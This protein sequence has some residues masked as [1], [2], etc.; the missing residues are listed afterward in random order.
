MKYCQE[1]SVLQFYCD[2][3]EAEYE[4][5]DELSAEEYQQDEQEAR[6]NTQVETKNN[7]RL[8]ASQGSSHFADLTYN[9]YKQRNPSAPLPNFENVK[10]SGTNRD[11][12]NEKTTNAN[13]DSEL[14][15]LSNYR[16]ANAYIENNEQGATR[17]LNDNNLKLSR[18]QNHIQYDIGIN[19]RAMLPLNTNEEG[20][21]LFEHN[22]DQ[23]SI[24]KLDKS[25]YTRESADRNEQSQCSKQLYNNIP[26]FRDFSDYIK[27]D[28][29]HL[30][31]NRDRR[32][33]QENDDKET[34]ESTL[35]PEENKES[36]T[37][38]ED[39]E[40]AIKR[41]VKKL[42][43]QELE[44][45]FNTLSEDKRALLKKIIETDYEKDNE[46]INKREITKKAGT[47]EENNYIENGQ[48]DSS[49]IQGGCSNID[50]NTEPSISHETTDNNK[51]NMNLTETGEVLSNK[52]NDGSDKPESTG[53]LG[54]KNENIK[55]TKSGSNLDS[56]KLDNEANVEPDT[57][58]MSKTENKRETNINENIKMEK[59]SDSLITD[60]DN[61]KNNQERFSPAD[62]S[63]LINEETELDN[64]YK[65]NIKR[66]TSLDDLSDR[67]AFIKS[68]EES[69]P[70]SN[71]YD[72]TNVFSGSNMAP[73]I[74]VKRKNAESAMTKRS[75]NAIADSNV[76]YFPNKGENDDEDNDE[77]SEFDEDGFYDRTS[78]YA[79]NSENNIPFDIQPHFS[80]NDERV[81]N[82]RS[83]RN[84]GHENGN[85]ERDTM[86][87]G[88]DTDNAM[89]G[90]EGVNDNLMYNSGSRSKRDS[91][92]NV[93]NKKSSEAKT[94]N[95]IRNSESKTDTD[96]YVSAP[97]YQETDAF[98]PLPRNYDGDLGR[99]KRIR[100]VKQLPVF[101][102]NN[103]DDE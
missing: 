94:N 21:L 93:D 33:I 69:F 70:N 65:K 61:N 46:G 67:S 64:L 74:R 75:A 56:D 51:R 28:K 102:S 40:S 38:N 81:L 100:R 29:L 77:G 39:E 5:N 101:K 41:H 57:Q 89:T 25:E 62:E 98:G 3:G 12:R 44:E 82:H 48:I 85:L 20:D 87:L 14:K 18:T 66:E 10:L 31:V 90:V 76:P 15:P 26:K 23:V 16:Q 50:V 35:S 2:A 13:L 4:N 83:S 73:M 36:D 52:N 63:E 84:Y 22:G 19:K 6:M 30:N 17:N 79:R 9:P 32:Q 80:G 72:E 68:L 1:L 49:K 86:S 11:I 24:N 78:N 7:G 45:L 37:A 103:S 43:A 59:S 99:Y 95:V 55:E 42:T 58:V 54:N 47:V 71:S 92:E 91:Q 53:E 34:N 8:Q 96:N 27:F 88:S 60:R 97:S